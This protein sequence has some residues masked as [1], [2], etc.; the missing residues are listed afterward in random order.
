MLEVVENVNLTASCLCSYDIVALRHVPRFVDFSSVI[1][2]NLNLY[3]LMLGN[4]CLISHFSSGN[5]PLRRFR[6]VPCILRRLEWYF[7]LHD[8]DIVLLIVASMRA[9][10]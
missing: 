4:T 10:Y 3:F 5:W 9:N 6:L 1:D 7:D 8:L 2:L